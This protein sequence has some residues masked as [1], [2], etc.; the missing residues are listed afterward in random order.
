MIAPEC[1]SR[2][3]VWTAY[4]AT[5][6]VTAAVLELEDTR[7]TLSALQVRRWPLEGWQQLAALLLTLCRCCL[8]WMLH[9]ADV[10]GAASTGQQGII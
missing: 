1:V 8:A 7:V 5:E 4:S 10:P 6:A 9:P 2:P 3:S